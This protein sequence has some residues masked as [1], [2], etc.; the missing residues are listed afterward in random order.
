[1]AWN[2]LE[3]GLAQ[4]DADKR[5]TVTSALGDIGLRADVVRFIESG[6]EDKEYRVREVAVATLGS[7]KSRNSI[8]KLRVALDDDS[9]VVSFAAAQALWAMGDRSGASIFIQVLAG[10]RKA[11]PGIIGEHLHDM[12]HKLHNPR[13]TGGFWR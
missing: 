9:P 5:A 10:D 12:K 2:V 1:M 7:L 6:L 4:E 13:G 11:A 8:A 3:E